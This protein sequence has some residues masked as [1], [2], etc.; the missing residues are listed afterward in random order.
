MPLTPLT[1]AA[2]ARPPTPSPCIVHAATVPLTHH[3]PTHAQALAVSAQQQHAKPLRVMI[4]GAPAAGKGTQCAKIVEKVGWIRNKFKNNLLC[5]LWSSSVSAYLMHAIARMTRPRSCAVTVRPAPAPPP[6]HALLT[7]PTLPTE[8]IP[9]R[10]AT[11]TATCCSTAWST[12][13][14]ATCCGP[15][16]RRAPL[17]ACGP[18]PSWTTG[19]SC[20]TRCAVLC[21]VRY[22]L[23]V[24][25]ALALGLGVRGCGCTVL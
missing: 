6:C 8:H 2:P 18:V 12:S 17:P 22:A 10:P 5:N 4:A 19:T 15:R 16:L 24:L 3:A 1:A 7:P 13:R 20:P 23:C 25:C 14:S 9:Y 11:G 21:C